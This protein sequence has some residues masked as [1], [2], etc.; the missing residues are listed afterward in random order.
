MNVAEEDDILDR[1]LHRIELLGKPALNCAFFR[2]RHLRVEGEFNI[3]L[4]ALHGFT[5]LPLAL[6]ILSRSDLYLVACN[7]LS[8]KGGHRV[9]LS[10]F[11]R[12]VDPVAE[13]EGRRQEVIINLPLRDFVLGAADG[14][15]CPDSA[16]Y[17]FPVLVVENVHVS[18]HILPHLHVFIKGERSKPSS[19][20]DL[21]HDSAVEV[22][23]VTRQH[24]QDPE[25][26]P[27]K[28]R[29]IRPPLV[30]PA[31]GQI[32]LGNLFE[33]PKGYL[34]VERLARIGLADGETRGATRSER[35]LTEE[36]GDRKGNKGQQGQA[37]E[38]SEEK[39][40]GSH[41]VSSV[42][43][44]RLG[45]GHVLFLHGAGQCRIG[46]NYCSLCGMSRWWSCL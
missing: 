33:Q 41:E 19:A 26:F 43:P 35:S 7:V 18:S 21:L 27:V 1:T 32:A 9:G 22:N 12:P 39:P 6:F 13:V 11:Y 38:P 36:V 25:G 30:S 5:C 4:A 46:F 23:A 8:G 44:Q 28:C 16:F 29:N 2:G 14:S 37:G 45:R 40:A 24:T 17:P 34:V 20:I 3:V 10:A 31:D 15:A 42:L